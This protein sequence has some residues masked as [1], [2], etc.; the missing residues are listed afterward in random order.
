M[1]SGIPFKR[2][3]KKRVSDATMLELRKALFTE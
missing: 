2:F 3:C 1:I